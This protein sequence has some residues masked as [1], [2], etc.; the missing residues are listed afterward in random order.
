M[1]SPSC[2]KWAQTCRHR[3][4]PDKRTV[5]P[6][7]HQGGLPRYYCFADQSLLGL[8]HNRRQCTVDT[9]EQLLTQIMEGAIALRKKK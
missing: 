1:P 8:R 3:K 9:L 6:C 7:P 5:R 4:T 2:V